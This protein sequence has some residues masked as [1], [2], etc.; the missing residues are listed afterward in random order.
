M[1]LS[2]DNDLNHAVNLLRSA[3][4]TAVRLDGKT[5]HPHLLPGHG[6]TTGDVVIDASLEEEV[7]EYVSHSLQPG[8]PRPRSKKTLRNNIKSYFKKRKAIKPD[9]I[10]HV[11]LARQRIT[12]T[13]HGK[14]M[15]ADEIIPADADEDMP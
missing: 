15:Y 14:I 13:G 2:Q 4:R 11:L 3:N 1:I 9:D 12:I 8:K 7:E 6:D 10:L 5:Q